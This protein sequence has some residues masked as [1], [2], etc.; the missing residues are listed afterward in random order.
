MKRIFLLIYYSRCLQRVPV[1]LIGP[2]LTISQCRVI[3]FLYFWSYFYLSFYRNLNKCLLSNEFISTNNG[4]VGNLYN[5]LPI[6]FYYCRIVTVTMKSRF[7]VTRSVTLVEFPDD[8]IQKTCQFLIC[9]KI[10]LEIL[11]VNLEVN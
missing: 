4:L 5:M 8:G 6:N 11:E 9:N 1:F 3:C 7:L 10:K 2:F